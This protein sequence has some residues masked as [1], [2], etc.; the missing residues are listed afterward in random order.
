MS[1]FPCELGSKEFAFIELL[2]SFRLIWEGGYFRIS[3]I[4][5]LKLFPLERVLAIWRVRLKTY[6]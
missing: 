3:L 5:C 1:K 6:D 4:Q 2:P